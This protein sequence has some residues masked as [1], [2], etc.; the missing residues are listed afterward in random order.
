LGAGGRQPPQKMTTASRSAQPRGGAYGHTGA[1]LCSHRKTLLRTSHLT[2]TDVMT[3][4]WMQRFLCKLGIKLIRS[5][6]HPFRHNAE[7]CSLF[8]YRISRT[9]YLM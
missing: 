7:C 8:A 4:R 1:L 6:P 2:R 3:V 9:Q 5:A